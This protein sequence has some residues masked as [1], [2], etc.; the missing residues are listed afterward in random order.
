M[1]FTSVRSRLES[2]SFNTASARGVTLLSS[3]PPSVLYK[4]WLHLDSNDQICSLL[5]ALQQLQH[6]VLLLDA[7]HLLLL[8][9]GELRD[10]LR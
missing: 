2:A 7:E 10:L 5:G 3:V 1:Y 9:W 6:L 4:E 8:L